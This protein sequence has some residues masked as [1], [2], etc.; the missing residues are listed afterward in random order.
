[1]VDPVT[2]SAFEQTMKAERG[3][4]RARLCEMLGVSQP[5]WRK[6]TESTGPVSNRMLALAMA[7]VAANLEPYGDLQ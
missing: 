3:W 1:M 6:L 2:L 4:S 5:T 7:A